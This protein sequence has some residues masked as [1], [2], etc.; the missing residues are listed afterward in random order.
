MA[1]YVLTVAPGGANLK[2][3]KEGSPRDGRGAIQRTKTSVI[4][5]GSTMGLLARWLTLEVSRPVLD[6]TGLDGAYDIDLKYDAIDVGDS[7]SPRYGSVFSAL[8]GVGLRLRSERA[9]VP[10]LVVDGA[11]EPSP[12]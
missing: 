11:Q 4:T 10:V 2:A 9:P 7:S 3:A 1:A 8:N 5:R 12:N 6:R